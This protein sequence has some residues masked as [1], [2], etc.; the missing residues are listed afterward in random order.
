M[1][2]CSVILADIDG[3]LVDKGQPMVSITKQAITQMHDRGVLFG[4]ATGRK[5]N[6]SMFDRNSEWGLDFDFDVIIGMNG[7]QLY[8]RFHPEIESYYMLE[9]EILREILKVMEPLHLNPMIYEKD[10]M[11][12][13]YFDEMISASMKRNNMEV[14]VTEGDTERLCRSRNYNVL[15]RFPEERTAEVAEYAKNLKSDLY[16]ATLTSPGIIEF[17]DPRVNKGLAL[18]KFSER[19]GIPVSEILAFGDMDNDMELLRDAGWGVCL[20]NGSD[21]TKAAADEITKYTCSEGGIGHYLY[22]HFLNKE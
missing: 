2:K 1:E 18:K 9:P 5:I 4:L 20:L 15:F 22:D 10:Y 6:R 11:V 7:G 19:N 13:V 21:V 3:T 8:D 16:K 12:T 17:M 14:I